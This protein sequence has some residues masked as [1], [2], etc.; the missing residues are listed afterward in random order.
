MPKPTTDLAAL[1]AND[2]AAELARRGAEAQRQQADAE[3]AWKAE[4]AES[5]R[6]VLDTWKATDEQ[7]R[8]TKRQ[9]KPSLDAP[10]STLR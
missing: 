7:L 9:P 8:H 6:V 10:S 1:P 2:L 5:D 4:Q 3:A